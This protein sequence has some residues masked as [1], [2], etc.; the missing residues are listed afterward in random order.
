LQGTAWWYPALA[1][2]VITLLPAWLPPLVVL[3]LRHQGRTWLQRLSVWV[4]PRQRLINAGVSILLAIVLG[5]RAVMR[6]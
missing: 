5:F 4:V 1:L 3:L 6:A 2:V